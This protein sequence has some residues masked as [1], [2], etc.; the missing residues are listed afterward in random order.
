MHAFLSLLTC[1][2]LTGLRVEVGAT[3]RDKAVLAESVVEL[4]ADGVYIGVHTTFVAMA[5]H[6]EGV[7]FSVIA[8]VSARG[9]SE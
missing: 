2:C 8:N 3:R 9:R 6:Y 1:I 7:D 5:S 4:I